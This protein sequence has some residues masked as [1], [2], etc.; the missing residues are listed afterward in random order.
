MKTNNEWYKSLAFWGQFINSDLTLKDD[1]VTT[2]LD[3]IKDKHT[4]GDLQNC[5]PFH[6]SEPVADIQYFYRFYKIE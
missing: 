3:C 4:L 1:V 5:S 2:F 6:V